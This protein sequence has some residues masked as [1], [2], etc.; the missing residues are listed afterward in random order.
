[1]VAALHIHQNLGLFDLWGQPVRYQEIVNAPACVPLSCAEP[2]APPAVHAG[3]IRVQVAEA[4]GKASGQQLVQLAALLVLKARSTAVGAGVLQ[5]NILMGHVQISAQ[6]HRL[7]AVQVFQVGAQ[8][9]LPLHAVVNAGQL[10]LGVGYIDI[11]L[12]LIHI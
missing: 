3:G 8:V 2:H 9:V 1:M 11:D 7:F 5:V 10:V 6:D 4:I 12:S